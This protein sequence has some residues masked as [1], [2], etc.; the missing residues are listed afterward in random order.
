MNSIKSYAKVDEADQIRLDARRKARKRMAVVALSSLILVIVVVSAV[1][2]CPPPCL[3]TATG[4]RNHQ[5]HPT[6]RLPRPATYTRLP[7]SSVK[8]LQLSSP[9]LTTTTSASFF[10]I[11][12]PLPSPFPPASLVTPPVAGTP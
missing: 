11:R 4:S 3:T 5:N 7:P 9:L 12:H 8:P 2:R 6:S 1:V 10:L